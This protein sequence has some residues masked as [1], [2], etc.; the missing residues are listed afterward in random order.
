MDTRLVSNA[1]KALGITS[2][3]P[4]KVAAIMDLAQAIGENTSIDRE[5]VKSYFPEIDLADLYLPKC[6]EKFYYD[7]E[8]LRSLVVPNLN[9]IRRL[10][11]Q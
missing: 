2:L 6:P 1:M 11:L 7:V 9:R 8:T 10:V 5:S 3:D 4:T